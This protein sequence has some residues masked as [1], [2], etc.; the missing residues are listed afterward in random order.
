MWNID[1]AQKMLGYSKGASR[2][3]KNEQMQTCTERHG[4]KKAYAKK[5]I[6][7][8]TEELYQAKSN[9]GPLKEATRPL[10]IRIP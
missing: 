2:I 4:E 7:F 9:A 3:K 5:H 1:M 10:H 6:G 8:Q